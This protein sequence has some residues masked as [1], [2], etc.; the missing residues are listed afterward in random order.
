MN[1]SIFSIAVIFTTFLAIVMFPPALSVRAQVPTVVVWCSVDPIG[2]HV[3]CPT[4]Y[5]QDP[6][7]FDICNPTF[8]S[9]DSRFVVPCVGNTSPT[10]PEGSPTPFPD[11]PIPPF[12]CSSSCPDEYLVPGYTCH[13]ANV[14]CC[15]DYIIP[16]LTPPPV[17]TI[18]YIDD[19][20]CGTPPQPCC[21]SNMPPSPQQLVDCDSP[22]YRCV[23]TAD[24]AIPYHCCDP[25][26]PG[27]CP[28]TL[29]DTGGA[30]C[31]P[32]HQKNG[33]ITALGC[34]QIERPTSF[35]NQLIPWAIGIGGFIALLALVYAG[36]L[37]TTSGGDLKKV[38]AGRELILSVVMGL[39][40]IAISALLINFIGATL[41]QLWPLG[42]SD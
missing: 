19:P 40:F 16:S 37:I 8:G 28:A 10:P 4:G 36:F 30:W 39:S 22:T 11:C 33:I 29:H 9:C 34:F 13:S 25:S 5:I 26:Q 14:D 7:V 24:I 6:D 42:F 18:P 17:P 27:L 41:L 38:A 15:A 31:D 12:R 35:I 32:E 3:V 21:Q 20:T 23:L 1:R 2:C